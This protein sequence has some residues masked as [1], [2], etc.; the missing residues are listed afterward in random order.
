MAT[1]S[2]ILFNF[3]VLLS[4]SGLELQPTD[5]KPDTVITSEPA[6]QHNINCKKCKPCDDAYCDCTTCGCNTHLCTCVSTC[7]EKFS[8]DA[9]FSLD[10]KRSGVCPS[11]ASITWGD[12][13]N[14]CC[15]GYNSDCSCLALACCHAGGCDCD[16]N[17]GDCNGCC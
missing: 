8:R 3:L 10:M 16:C 9:H 14:S 7:A 11:C 1:R 15:D 12:C 5:T 17:M 6:S 4:E 13:C 2:A